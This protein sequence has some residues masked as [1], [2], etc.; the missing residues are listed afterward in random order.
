[1]MVVLSPAKKLDENSNIDLRS[2]TQ[3]PLLQATSKLVGLLREKSEDELGALMSI[4]A[5]LSSLNAGRYQRFS[6]PFTP[7][8]ARPA[9][10]TFD[11]DTY[12]GFAGREMCE[13]DL[14][15]A[16]DRVAI[17]SGLYGVLRP[18]DLM[19]PYRLEMGTRLAT[20]RG[21]DLYAFWG[22]EITD[23]LTARLSA[24]RDSTLVNLASQ[25]Y[26]RSVKVD[27]LPGR[28][29]TPVFQEVK[30]GKARTISFLAKRARGTMARFVVKNRLE[31][32]EDLK[33]FREGGY[34]WEEGESDELRWVFRRP[35]PTPKG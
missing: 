3:P 5:K 13:E 30:E 11:G 25:E 14:L 31:D 10:L 19:Q 17:L 20:D 8:N 26:F 21:K 34:R 23:V 18:L 27:A 2:S 4:S 33:A 9:A 29:V 12:V 22:Q 1:M 32:P 15:W 7:S 24:H 35:Q 16:Q 28:V 6:L